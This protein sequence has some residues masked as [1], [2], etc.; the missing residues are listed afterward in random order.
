MSSAEI[1]GEKRRIRARALMLMSVAL[2][3]YFGFIEISIYRS[4]R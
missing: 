1:P 2:A 3:L 4:Y